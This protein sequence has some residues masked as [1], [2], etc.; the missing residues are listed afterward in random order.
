MRIEIQIFGWWANGV[1]TK[2]SRPSVGRAKQGKASTR[3]GPNQ[4]KRL[5]GGHKSQLTIH[6]SLLEDRDTDFWLVGYWSADQ[7]ISKCGLSQG[8]HKRWSE[9]EKAAVRWSQLAIHDSRRI[10]LN[11]RG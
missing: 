3:D 11:T 7:G 10:G 6:D 9:P 4:R 8:K 1:R 2:G 5:S